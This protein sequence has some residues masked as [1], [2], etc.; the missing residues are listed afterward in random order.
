MREYQARTRAVAHPLPQRARSHPARAQAACPPTPG[1]AKDLGYSDL[2]RQ[3]IGEML[4]SP[5]RALG[6]GDSEDGS[7]CKPARAGADDEEEFDDGYGAA[8]DMPEHLLT[9]GIPA[10]FQR[11]WTQ[12]ES[13]SKDLAEKKDRIDGLLARM[14]K[15]QE[16]FDELEHNQ[17]HVERREKRSPNGRV[18][19]AFSLLLFLRRGEATQ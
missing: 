14:R 17:K 5:L 3:M 8:W 2:E 19:H 7:A 10:G 13:I 1:V 18:N 11:T 9:G 6:L 15:L 4:T 12:V 16:R